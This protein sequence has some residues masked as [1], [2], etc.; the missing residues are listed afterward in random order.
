[1]AEWDSASLTVA[2]QVRAVDPAGNV[3][4]RFE[5]GLNKHSWYYRPDLP[6]VLI[7]LGSLGFIALLVGAALEIRRRRKKRAME[8]YAIKRMRR[9][10]KGIKKD[11]AKKDVDWRKVRL[12]PCCAPFG[13]CS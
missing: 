11:A 4:Q 5:E 1:M 10:F 8:R 12:F 3:N 9:K 6:W 7:I 13:P 2:S